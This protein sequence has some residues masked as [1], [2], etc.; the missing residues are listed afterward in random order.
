[1]R[2]FRFAWQPWSL[3]GSVVALVVA[4]VAWG[5]PKASAEGGAAGLP[6]IGPSGIS[7]GLSKVSGGLVA[8]TAGAVAPGLPSEVFV[9]DQ[10]GRIYAV[11]VTKPNSNPVLFGDVSALIGGPLGCYDWNYDERG[12][13]GLAFSPS[14]ATDGIVYT[15]ISTAPGGCDVY[16]WTPSLLPNHTDMLVAWHV[17]NPTSTKATIDPRSARSVLSFANPFYD[18]NGGQLAFGPDGYLYIGVGD[19]GSEDGENPFLWQLGPDGWV[20]T[21]CTAVFPAHACAQGQ[22]PGGNAQDLSILNGKILRIDPTG[23]SAGSYGIPADN[24]FV[25]VSQAR[26]E[27]WAYGLRNPYSFS[28]T[29]SGL[30]AGDVGQDD[31]EELDLITKGQ[32]YGWPQKEGTFTFHNGDELAYDPHLDGGG[33]FLGNDG[34]VTTADNSPGVPAGL[35]DPIFEYDHSQGISVIAGYDYAG[36]A[37][38]QLRH[39]Y[40]FADYA[41]NDFGAYGRLFV[42]DPAT[43]GVGELA[44]SKGALGIDVRGIVR[45]AQ[46]EIYLLGNPDGGVSGRNGVVLKITRG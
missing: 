37:V 14:Y 30:V 36:S 26:P 1:M 39:R 3:T 13:I 12:L 28:F 4:A 33:T 21:A 22:A 16:S 38:P 9:A 32:N 35:T 43:G 24:P 17:K 15:Y 8:P 42:R 23:T 31:V 7:V 5:S 34:Y 40:V 11:D 6:P 46:G 2:G 18:H 41:A 44:V 19:G 25:G 29:S 10:V 20:P 27:I 45:D